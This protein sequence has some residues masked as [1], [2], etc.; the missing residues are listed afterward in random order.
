MR[1]DGEAVG[2]VPEPLQVEKQRRV[3]LQ[4]NLATTGEVEDLAALTTVMRALRDAHDGHVVDAGILHYLAYSRNLAL[5]AVDQQQV[6]PLAALT[7]WVLLFEPG[8]AAFE[9]F[10]HHRE[11]VARLRLRLLYVELAIAVLAE[12]FGAGDDHRAG[13]VRAHDVA[14]VVNLDALGHGRKL[15]RIGQLAQDLALR[16]RLREPAVERFLGIPPSLIEQLLA[17]AA[18]RDFEDDL[19]TGALGQRLLQQPA[20]GK[21]AIDEDALGRRQVLVELDEETREHFLLR[22]VAGVRGEEGAMAPVLPPTDEEALD[23]HGS[24]LAGE[25]EHVGIAQTF[26]MHRLRSLNVS[27][28]AQAVAVDCGVLVILVLGG[29]GH[30]LR[31]SRLH[32]GRLAGQ[33]VLRVLDQLIIV[34]FA[35]PPHARR[36]AALDLV[37]QAGPRPV[38][39]IAVRAASQQEQLLQRVEG[40]GDRAGAREGAE[41]LALRPTS[42]TMLLHSRKGVVLAQQDERETLVVAQKHVVGWPESL[43]QLRFQQQRLRLRPRRDDCHRPR[44]RHHPLQPLRHA[45]DLS[46]VGHAVLKRT[47]LADVEHFAPRILHPVDAW[48]HR[49]R[50]QHLADGRD[51]LLE[52]R[53]I[54]TANGIGRLVLVEALGRS[55]MVGTICRSAIHPTDLGWTCP[56][57][58]PQAAALACSSS[59]SIHSTQARAWIAVVS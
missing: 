20:I 34:G 40:P 43:D 17:V 48:P 23:R 11:V 35:D 52:I 26:S 49:Q 8:E 24:G 21:L 38:L 41:I 39:E 18:L 46:V 37:E 30:L 1:P 33:E 36:R 4:G 54:G 27:E 10:A 57:C 3:R 19:A 2:L 47:S 53:L 12:T 59:A 9:H 42:A 15:E 56:L 6:R 31:Q 44:L 7:V 16:R 25:R 32:A 51:A 22:H 29:R 5:T 50:L 14:I 13:R 55:R 58:E 28:R 45:R